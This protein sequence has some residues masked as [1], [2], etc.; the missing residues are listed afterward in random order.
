MVTVPS[1]VK[2]AQDGSY[3][4]RAEDAYNQIKKMKAVTRM[5]LIKENALEADEITEISNSLASL[6]EEYKAISFDSDQSSDEDDQAD[7]D[8]Y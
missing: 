6:V 7:E 2:L 8:D 4:S 3:L 1:L 5:Q